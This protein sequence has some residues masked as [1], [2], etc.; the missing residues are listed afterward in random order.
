MLDLTNLWLPFSTLCSD[1]SSTPQNSV[2]LSNNLNCKQP[3]ALEK[4]AL[5]IMQLQVALQDLTYCVIYN[6]RVVLWDWEL[7]QWIEFDKASSSFGSHSSS[8]VVNS[9]Q[10]SSISRKTSSRQT[11]GVFSCTVCI[12]LYNSALESLLCFDYVP[13]YETQHNSGVWFSMAEELNLFNRIDSFVTTWT[14]LSW[15]HS[16]ALCYEYPILLRSLTI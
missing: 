7:V 3:I 8:G 1:T 16:S 14:L 4:L 10:K 5:G 15:F 12:A 6:L 11:L 2:L 9:A 13:F